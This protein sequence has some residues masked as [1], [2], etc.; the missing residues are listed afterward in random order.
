MEFITRP[1]TQDKYITKESDYEKCNFERGD[2]WLDAGGNIGAFAVKY[3]SKVDRIISFE[4]D[5]QNYRLLRKNLKK[6]G[7]EN[8]KTSQKCL[9]G[10]QDETRKFY[11]NKKT[12]KGTHSLL[13]KGGRKEIIVPCVNINRAWLKHGFNKMKVDVEG[14][15]LELLM[16]FKYYESIDEI[17]FE[18]HFNYLK[19]HPEHNKFKEL[20]EHLRSKGFKLEHKEPKKHWTMIVRATR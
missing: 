19:D 10:N 1:S 12:N 8:V 7:I 4:P 18:Y 5:E 13:V 20:T 17:I 3:A 9:V 6:N 11:L 2:V 16:A 15:E 14:A